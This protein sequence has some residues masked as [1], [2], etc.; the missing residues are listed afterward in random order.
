MAT[1][2]ITV[3]CSFGTD[4][5]DTPSYLDI[6][7]YVRAIE[8]RIGRNHE[9]NRIEAGVAT[10]T[11][12]N[13]DRRF[14]PAYTSSPYYPDV[15]PM[16]RVRVRAN[17]S[18]TDY[19][20]FVGFVEA[21]TPQLPGG[22]ISEL[23]VPLVDAFRYFA[24]KKLTV[25]AGLGTELS[26]AQVSRIL[27]L[28]SW[29]AGERGISA[30]QS[31]MQ[32]LVMTQEYVLSRFQTI[33][34]SENGLFYIAPDGKVT[35]RDRHYRLKNKSTSVATFGDGGGA[36]LPYEELVFSLD[37]TL[38]YNEIIVTRSGSPVYVGTAT[39]TDSETHYF[40]RTLTKTTYVQDTNEPQDA[41]YWL[42]GIYKDPGLRAKRMTISGYMD[43]SL[44]PHVLGRG[45]G[46]R[47]TVVQR[48]PGGGS[49]ISQEVH[50][51]S[52]RHVIDQRLG[53][54]GV[55]RTTWELSPARNA[56]YWVL[57]DLVLSVLDSTTRLA[58]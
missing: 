27:D 21:W 32:E 47:I 31:A 20:M 2:T 50:I 11:L 48:P 49:A 54:D 40:S 57:D 3:E 30:G 9:L 28:L 29:P 6:S 36:E 15:L 52:I 45:I 22:L 5:L 17:Y 56:Q 46:D 42:L 25:A 38:I 55:W 4:P 33:A 7:D 44:W 14:D 8:T 12:D 24:G 51:E 19:N 1:P 18:G 23:D 41:A 16:K 35:F 26:S 53:T 43:D 13:A 37:D 39:D 34:D 10:I 58:Y